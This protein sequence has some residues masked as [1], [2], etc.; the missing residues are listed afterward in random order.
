MSE[1]DHP[2]SDRPEALI[3]TPNSERVDRPDDED[4]SLRVEEW[5]ESATA[6]PV[7][8]DSVKERMTGPQ[9]S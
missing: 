5:Q 9:Q 4:L 1:H 8:L 6:G 3:R 7:A 2:T